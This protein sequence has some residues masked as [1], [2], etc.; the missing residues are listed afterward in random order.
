MH[1]AEGVFH[2][3]LGNRSLTIERLNATLTCATFVQEYCSVIAQ[4]LLNLP[5]T[6]LR[7]KP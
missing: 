2:N 6:I 5:R 3:L 4:F 7:R 1:P